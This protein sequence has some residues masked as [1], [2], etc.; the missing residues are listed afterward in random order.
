MNKSRVP[1]QLDLSLQLDE[2]V[3]T[4]GKIKLYE[5]FQYSNGKGASFLDYFFAYEGT[6]P[7][8]ILPG[9]TTQWNEIVKQ[10]AVFDMGSQL[11]DIHLDDF[12][13]TALFEFDDYAK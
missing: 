6:I 9:I 10:Q 7:M 12:Y 13:E 3:E 11:A 5:S 1:I 4:Q 2:V 8:A